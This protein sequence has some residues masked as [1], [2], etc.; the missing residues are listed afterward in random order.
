MKTLIAANWKM[1]GDLGWA[2]KLSEFRKH[3]PHNEKHMECLICPPA[4]MIPAL[5]EQ[6]KI[7]NMRIG[8]QNCHAEV[9]GAF[10]GEI[11][12]DMIA[13]AGAD[14][15]IVGHSERRSIFGE[16][17]AM[18][19]AKTKAAQSASLTP[20]VCI[21]ESEVERRAQK[22]LEVATRQLTDSIPEDANS[23]NIVVAYE[24]VWAIGTGLTPSLEDIDVM[25]NHL[26]DLLEKRFGEK[27]GSK[28][29]ILYG[30]SVKPG[31][32]KDILAI[33]NVNGALIGG[34]SLE[35]E[36]LAAI[37]KAA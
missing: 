13:G 30:G 28:V 17:D 22:E 25:H 7:N 3:Y 9:S 5:V 11:S 33:G 2:S 8:A 31:N 4:F 6:G 1:H 20:I 34:A 37:A 21:G 35:M 16:T 24:P 18:I 32:A 29:Q 14:Y 23:E 27:H 26:R 36:S 10:T 15:V 19:A 12:A